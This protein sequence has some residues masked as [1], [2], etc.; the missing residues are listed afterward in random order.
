MRDLSEKAQVLACAEG[1]RELYE[2]P[3]GWSV[4]QDGTSAK[5][6]YDALARL[7]ADA[8]AED[9]HLLTGNSLLV[10]RKPCGECGT[11]TYNMVLVADTPVCVGC[12]HK[13]LGVAMGLVTP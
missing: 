13:A 11:R 3:Q 1:W 4:R 5:D 2:G 9:V 7:G 12:L 10:S 6:V 8:T